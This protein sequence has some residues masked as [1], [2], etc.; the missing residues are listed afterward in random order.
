MTD[1]ANRTFTG[2][3]GMTLIDKGAYDSGT[4]YN[5]GDYTFIYSTLP[6][7]SGIKMVYVCATDGTI[8]VTPQGNPGQWLLDTCT[9]TCAGCALRF[10]GTTLRGS[11]FPGVARAPFISRA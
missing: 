7:F 9:H 8:G 6:A 11:F 1:A 10:A 5:R 2:F 3:Y 4:T